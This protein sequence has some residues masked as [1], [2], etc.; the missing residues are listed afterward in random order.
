M[1][2]FDPQPFLKGLRT[3]SFIDAIGR[4]YQHRAYILDLVSPTPG[5]VLFG[6]AVTLSFLPYREDIYDQKLHNFGRLFYQAVGDSPQGKVLVMACNGHPDISMGGSRKL[7]RLKNHRMAGML[8]DGRIRDFEELNTYEPVIYCRGEATHWG[9]DT[10]IPFAANIPV[11]INGVAVLPGDYI[12]ADSSGVAI[13]PAA[14]LQDI[15]EEAVRVEEEDDRY[16]E[17]IKHEDPAIVLQ[18]ESADH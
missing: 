4:T 8:C 13:I 18:G 14:R 15:F 12:Y 1:T 17:D 10:I 3:A 7:S 5:K 16:M 2:A 9:G 11:S 6:R